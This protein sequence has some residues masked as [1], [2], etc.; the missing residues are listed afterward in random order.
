MVQW[1]TLIASALMM[2][3]SAQALAEESAEQWVHR[4]LTAAR[5]VSYHGQSI[6]FSG[7]KVTSLDI[8]HAPIDH[9]IWERVVHLSGEPAEILRK[10]SS[11]IC[12]YP[13]SSSRLKVQSSPLGKL[14]ALEQSA[15]TVSHYYRFKQ[16]GYDRVAGREAVRIDVQPLDQFRYG[17]SLWLDKATGVLLKSQTNPAEGDPLEIFEFVSLEIGKPIPRSAFEPSPDLKAAN[18]PVQL[19]TPAH[20]V[21]DN[22]AWEADWLP[23]GFRQAGRTSTRADKPD[24]SARV[25]TDGLAAFTIFYEPKAPTHHETTRSHGATVAVNHLL[26]GSDAMVTVV[27]EVP[28]ITADKVAENVKL[29]AARH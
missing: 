26:P 15:Q 7:G 2:L 17:Y 3:V 24:M 6:L 20:V 29:V 28:L 21:P 11:I 12:L 10:G 27:G 23:D 8:Y 19:N 13:G 14:T 4:M 18:P 5:E 25:Y 16:A 22:G 1:R 9:Q